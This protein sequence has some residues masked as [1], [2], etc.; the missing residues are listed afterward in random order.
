VK[1]FRVPAG[2]VAVGFMSLVVLASLFAVIEG[3]KPQ[4]DGGARVLAMLALPGAWQAVVLALWTSLASTALATLLAAFILARLAE[5]RFGLLLRVI[6]P[7]LAMPH[8]AFAFGLFFLLTPGGLLIRLLHALTG[9]FPEPP[10]VATV[11]DPYGVALVFGLA[12]KETPFL[13]IIGLAALERLKIRPHLQAG[14][15]LGYPGLAA[16]F[17]T[18]WPMLYAS[19]RLPVLAVLIYGLSVVDM[20]MILGPTTPPTFAVMLTREIASAGLVGQERASGGALILF[21]LGLAA[22]LIWL[23]L[24]HAAA[25]LRNRVLERGYRWRRASAVAQWSM[26][27]L[28]TLIALI[29]IGILGVLVI[30]SLAGNW[31]YPAP[32]PNRWSLRSWAV[33][34]LPAVAF[35][36][37]LWFAFASALLALL[38]V[39]LLLEGFRKTA[40]I[41]AIM[42]L[43]LLLPQLSLV[44]GFYRLSLYAGIESQ[45]LAV[46]LAHLLYVVPYLYL[47]LAPQHRGLDPRFGRMGQALGKSPWRVFLSIRLPMLMPSL[48]I[49]LAIG[50]SVSFALYLP[51]LIPGGGRIMTV[52]TEAVAQASGGE[53]RVIAVQAL[54]QAILPAVG[55][56]TAMLLPTLIRRAMGWAR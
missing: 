55:F 14:R 39:M 51:T 42:F 38:M 2:L 1:A 22:V 3:L 35:A 48:L 41:E 9:W 15:A 27:A 19:I 23:V 21:W 43:P 12:L 50:L 7:V 16:F 29:I 49:A 53:R 36:N 25:L 18:G 30:A 20:A 44:F 40:L 5:G 8:A 54:W 31:T 34:G 24:E 46:L 13:V 10:A 56:L 4:S 37:S 32:M 26:P 11:Q 6:R 28:S 45:S 33:P 17:A 52:T 47:S